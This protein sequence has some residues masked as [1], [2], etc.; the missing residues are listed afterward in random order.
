MGEEIRLPAGGTVKLTAR[1]PLKSRILLFRDG[2]MIYEV[3]DSAL[4][5]WT[6]DRR[7][8]YRVEVYPERLGSL[9]TGKPWIISN[10]I[11]VR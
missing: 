2:Q 10:P 9:L 3:S 4:A 7:G 8:V 6:A 5:E 1:T 11:F